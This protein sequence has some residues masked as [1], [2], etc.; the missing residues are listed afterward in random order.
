MGVGI[1]TTWLTT[2]DFF[3]RVEKLEEC[4]YHLEGRG[5][6]CS[7]SAPERWWLAIVGRSMAAESD[8][9]RMNNIVT[10]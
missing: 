5:Q 4:S 1:S 2:D 10:W 7:S 3:E 8:L 9:W 6:K